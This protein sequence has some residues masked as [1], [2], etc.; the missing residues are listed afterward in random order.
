MYTFI[1]REY[2]DLLVPGEGILRFPSATLTRFEVLD[3]GCWRWAGATYGATG[4]GMVGVAVDGRRTTRGAH[5]VFYMAHRGPIASG[6]E[7]DH[8]CR[9]RLCVNPDHLEAVDT[10]TNLLRGVGASARNAAK[11]SCPQGHP[12]DEANTMPRGDG[13]R[14][15]RACRKAQRSTPEAKAKHAAAELRRY[16]ARKR[17]HD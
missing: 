16:H 12:Y 3:D 10:R 1:M 15:C 14:V 7:L 17:G 2:V 13:S 4:Y 9:R 6:L 8:L 11:T 5:R